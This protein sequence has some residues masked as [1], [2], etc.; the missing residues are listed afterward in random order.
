MNTYLNIQ[1]IKKFIYDPVIA[2]LIY[3]LLIAYAILIVTA[4][5]FIAFGQQSISF[6]KIISFPLLWVFFNYV[7]G[8][9]GH[10]RLGTLIQKGLIL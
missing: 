1:R 2:R 6:L 10:F 4:I 8:L 3:D 9:Y 7:I 5:L